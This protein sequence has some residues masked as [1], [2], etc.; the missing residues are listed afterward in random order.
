MKQILTFF[1]SLSFLYATA[2]SPCVSGLAD[3]LYPCNQITLMG[4]LSPDELNAVEL[5]GYYLND[6]WG[7]TD[8]SNNKEYAIVGLKD[9]VAFIDISTPTNP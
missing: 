1:I 9:G 8:P 4:H 3:G 6:I 5:G 7:W 2:Q